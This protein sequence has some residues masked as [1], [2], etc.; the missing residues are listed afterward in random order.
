MTAA[1]DPGAAPEIRAGR[2]AV[3]RERLVVLASGVLG[4]G[5]ALLAAT[6]TWL[7]VTVQD[8]LAGSG[9]LHP[10]GRDVAA[11]VAAAALVG[12]AASIAAVTMRRIGRQVAGLLLVA[13]GAGIASATVRVLSDPR[14]ATEEVLRQATGRTGDVA[15]SASVT[16]VWPWLALVAGL[17]VALSGVTTIVRGRSWSGLSD[18]YDAPGASAAAARADVD[19]AEPDRAARLDEAEADHAWEALSRGE[20]PTG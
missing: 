3:R 13:A 8:P 19:A 15:A 10:S 2:S 18:R 4:A 14:A 9:R 5:L 12:L 16:G 1:A 6:R 11:L 20:D 7:D 17:L